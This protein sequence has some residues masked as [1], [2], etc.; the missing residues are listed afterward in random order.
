MGVPIR[1]PVFI[2]FVLKL[3]T[4]D[5]LSSHIH[6]HTNAHLHYV[7][8]LCRLEG[9]QCHNKVGV[10]L[11]LFFIS[12]YCSRMWSKAS[13][14]IVVSWQL[15]YTALRHLTSIKFKLR[16]FQ[17]YKKDNG[18]TTQIRNFVNCIMH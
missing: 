1:R 14:L 4:H 17:V 12:K 16:I 2:G 3:S 5:L 13:W 10:S 8:Q 6:A 18:M 7:N 9:N 11:N 15:L